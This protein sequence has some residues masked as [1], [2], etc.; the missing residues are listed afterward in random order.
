MQLAT[1]WHRAVAG[2]SA[3]AQARQILKAHIPRVK[4]L[5][6]VLKPRSPSLCAPLNPAITVALSCPLPKHSPAA[7]AGAPQAAG[8]QRLPLQRPHQLG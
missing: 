5:L 2:R 4:A 1:R 8:V 6:V 7:G 3:H